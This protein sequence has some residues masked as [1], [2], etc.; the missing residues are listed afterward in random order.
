VLKIQ[1]SLRNMIYDNNVYLSSDT[2][3][4]KKMG[5]IFFCQLLSLFMLNF[6]SFYRHFVSLLCLRTSRE[7]IKMTKIV[8][9]VKDP[10]ASSPLKHNLEL[11]Y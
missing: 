3:F 2:V 9:H 10:Q 8:P 6:V 5:I 11:I 4:L 7:F 1:V